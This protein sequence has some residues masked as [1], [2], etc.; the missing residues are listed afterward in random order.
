M[1]TNAVYKPRSANQKHIWSAVHHQRGIHTAISKA[2]AYLAQLYVNSN[3]DTKR[4]YHWT[5]RPCRPVPY[6][7]RDQQSTSIPGAAVYQQHG[8]LNRD[9]QRRII[10]G[11]TVYQHRGTSIAISTAEVC[12]ALLYI[13]SH[14]NPQAKPIWTTRQCRPERYIN[15]DQ[16]QKTYLARLYVTS[17]E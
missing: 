13:N 14:Q 5:T 1:S 12:L 2:K 16:Q 9:Q 11:A 4:N 15:R 6:V 7:N 8:I 3:H 10:S 17:A